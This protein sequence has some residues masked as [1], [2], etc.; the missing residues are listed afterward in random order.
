VRVYKALGGVLFDAWSEDQYGGTGHQFD[1]SRLPRADAMPEGSPLILAGGLTPD[2]VADAVRR[3]GPNM[4]DVSG[5]V[6]SAPGIKD[7]TKVAT[8]IY[9]A[10]NA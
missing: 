10:K 4:V 3:V 8:F 6:E 5:G 2:N 9:N 1:W 7:V